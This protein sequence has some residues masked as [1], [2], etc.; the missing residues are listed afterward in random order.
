VR[1]ARPRILLGLWR[2]TATACPRWRR[3]RIDAEDL[4][5]AVDLGTDRERGL[6]DRD[7]HFAGQGELGEHGG[8]A[9]PGRIAQAA[10]PVC[11]PQEVRDQPVQRRGV[12]LEVD[13]ELEL[14]AG[15]H[16]RHPVIPDRPGDEHSIAGPDRAGAEVEVVLDRADSR[17]VDV[18]AIGLAALDHLCVPGRHLDPGRFGRPGHRGDDPVEIRQGTLLDDEAAESAIGRAPPSPG[19]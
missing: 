19:R 4:A 15:D 3:K 12:G 10:H 8:D 7:A 2:T 9:A 11:R 1:A 16:D 17:G 18:E 6:V 14:A 13:L 5:G